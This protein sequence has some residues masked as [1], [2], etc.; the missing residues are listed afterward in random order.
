MLEDRAC[1][2]GG[3][4]LAPSW[5]QGRKWAVQYRGKWIHFGAQGYDDFTEHRDVK[6]RASY[7]ARHGAIKLADDRLARIVKTSPAYWAWELLW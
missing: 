4:A 7:R 1:Q 5:R 6:R 2:L 3:T